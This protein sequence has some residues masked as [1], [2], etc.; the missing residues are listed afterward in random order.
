[1]AAWEGHVPISFVLH[2]SEVAR[3]EQP[4]PLHLI[5]PRSSFLFA[6][7][8]FRALEGQFKVFVA[9]VPN[10]ALWI[11][12]E[13]KPVP[14]QYPIGVVHDAMRGLAAPPPW[15]LT[16]RFSNFPDQHVV[17]FRSDE[18]VMSFF[19]N[20]VKESSFLTFGSTVPLRMMEGSDWKLYWKAVSNSNFEK[21]CS[22]HE[23][24]RKTAK[25]AVKFF[26]L[27]IIL[28]NPDGAIHR[29]IQR[30]IEF[31]SDITIRTCMESIL[32]DFLT[33]DVIFV[34]H[35]I[36]LLPDM[37]LDFLFR[38]LLHSDGFLYLHVR[39]EPVDQKEE[40]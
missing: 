24:Q 14:W 23:L 32:A 15:R 40:H 19:K 34:A 27:R 3:A 8:T 12:Y 26:P 37:S 6:P 16:V 33:K 7:E 30:K 11:E 20:A 38:H 36:N 10:S 18:E 1:V 35:G 31:K 39:S 29:V 17:R 5:L 9:Q 13:D 25:S 2:A 22:F 4:L 21:F 28:S